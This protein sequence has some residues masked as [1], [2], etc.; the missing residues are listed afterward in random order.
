MMRRNREHLL[1]RLLDDLSKIEIMITYGELVLD[2]DRQL[3]SLNVDRSEKLYESA[4]AKPI[5]VT[6]EQLSM[7]KLSIETR[8]EYDFIDWSRIRNIRN[9][10]CHTYEDVEFDYVY[11]WID[12]Y[13]QHI[14]DDLYS[15]KY[16]IE[17]RI[18]I[19]D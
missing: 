14:I 12:C 7:D 2:N 8:Q 5:D 17:R 18:S 10:L 15:I 3:K 13:L 1:E 9:F 6:G 16:D 11:N 4:I 19:L